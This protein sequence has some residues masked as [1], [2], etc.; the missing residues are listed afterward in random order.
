MKQI[1]NQEHKIECDLS[2]RLHMT[3]DVVVIEQVSLIA[4]ADHTS[5]VIYI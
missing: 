2:V 3:R 4:K 5:C 1:E